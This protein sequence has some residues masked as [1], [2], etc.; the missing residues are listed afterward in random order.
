MTY[1]A[2]SN[3]AWSGSGY[4]TPLRNAGAPS[5]GTSGT[6]A[7]QNAGAGAMLIDTTNG[8][9]YINTG[10]AASPTWAVVGS[11]S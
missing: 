1:I 5:N 11:Q 3:N 2:G 9:E 7:N 8:K 4:G 6:Y 10:T